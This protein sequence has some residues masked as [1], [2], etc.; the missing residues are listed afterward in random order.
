M[1][2]GRVTVRKVVHRSARRSNAASSRVE[3]MAQDTRQGKKGDGKHP[4]GLHQASPQT[5]EGH[6]GS[7]EVFVTRPLLPKSNHRQG[8]E[9]RRDHRQGSHGGGFLPRTLLST[10]A[11]ESDAVDRVASRPRRMLP[12]G[13][14][15]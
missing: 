6:R 5:V 10:K 8:E 11:R 1:Q 15:Y 12:E 14:R 9:K 3:S 13:R 4:H 2:R 7:E